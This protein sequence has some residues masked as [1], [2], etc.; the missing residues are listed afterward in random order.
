[1]DNLILGKAKNRKLQPSEKQRYSHG[2]HLRLR[3]GVSGG[4]DRKEQ[5]GLRQ[6]RAVIQCLSLLFQLMKF[7]IKYNSCPVPEQ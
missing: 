5:K 7:K 1:M 2:P 4:R 6:L 3:N